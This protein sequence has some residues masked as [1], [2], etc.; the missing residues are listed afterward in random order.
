MGIPFRLDEPRQP[1]HRRFRRGKAQHWRV[2]SQWRMWFITAGSGSSAAYSRSLGTQVQMGAEC[3]C[4]GKFRGTLYLPPT[5]RPICFCLGQ[6]LGPALAPALLDKGFAVS[7]LFLLSLPHSWLINDAKG[8][9]PI[10]L[11]Y[12]IPKSDWGDCR[13]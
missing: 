5:P 11:G 2:L 13:R 3:T 1:L 8:V 12:V 4:G 7:S 10:S 9:T 6:A